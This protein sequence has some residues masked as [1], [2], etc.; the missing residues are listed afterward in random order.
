M[1]HVTNDTR[2]TSRNVYLNTFSFRTTAFLSFPLFYVFLSPCVDLVLQTIVCLHVTSLWRR[3]I[4]ASIFFAAGAMAQRSNHYPSQYWNWN[5]GTTLPRRTITIQ[6]CIVSGMT[7]EWSNSSRT[8]AHKWRLVH[9]SMSTSALWTCV[10]TIHSLKE[11]FAFSTYSRT[12]LEDN[13][14]WESLEYAKKVSQIL[15]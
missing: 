3:V 12:P 1:K 6:V 14:S 11:E 7:G 2:D 13:K 4:N 8:L 9:S 10:T 15:W 5:N